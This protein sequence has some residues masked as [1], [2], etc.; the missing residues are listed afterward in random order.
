MK[1]IKVKIPFVIGWSRRQTQLED[2]TGGA[3]Y[4]FNVYYSK[5]NSAYI[6]QEGRQGK[7][8]SDDEAIKR[9]EIIK[10]GLITLLNFAEIK[11]FGEIRRTSNQLHLDRHTIG[12][13]LCLYFPDKYLSLFSNRHMSECLNNFG[14]LDNKTNDSDAFEKREVLLTF[15]EKDEVMKNWPNRKYVDFLYKEILK[16]EPESYF[17]LRT[18][19]GEYSDEPE[20]KY[21]FKEGIPDTSITI[22]GA[23]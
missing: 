21:N 7:V 1:A 14:L 5:K 4:G 10:T 6:I 22:M 9:L 3:G 2:I 12:K 15:K 18:G 16:N 13:I 11:D 17:I 8:A 20:R 19:G 23:L